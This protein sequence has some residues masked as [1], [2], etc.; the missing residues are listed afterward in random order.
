KSGEYDLRQVAREWLKNQGLSKPSSGEAFGAVVDDNDDSASTPRPY[1][2]D[3]YV[4]ANYE[5]MRW[6]VKRLIP[7]NSVGALYG[8][9]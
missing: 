8:L 9:P 4:V 1:V 7:L 3:S 2:R 6:L 5:P